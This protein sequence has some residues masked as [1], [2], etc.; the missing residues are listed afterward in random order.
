[1]IGLSFD[2]PYGV[3]HSM[4]DGFL[5]MNRFGDPGYRY[6]VLLARIWGTLALRL[7]NADLLP[8]DVAT[9]ARHLRAFLDDLEKA[10]EKGRVDLSP[11]RVRLDALEAAGRRLDE[12]ARGALASGGP[13]PEVAARVNRGLIAVERNWLDPDGLPGRPWFEHTVYA[14]R[15]TYAHLELPGLTE[16]AEAKDWDRAA[17][18]AEVLARAVDRN[19]EL[20]SALA[21]ELTTASAEHP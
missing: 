20:A 13:P 21:R 9:Y 11:L 12:D 10:T 17:R 5:W 19:T 14:A 18:Q 15:Y 7:A 1:V 3:Y 8:M 6:H 2:G 4:Y 16:A